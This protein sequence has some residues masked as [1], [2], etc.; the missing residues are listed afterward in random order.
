MVA[1][2]AIPSGY[3]NAIACLITGAALIA[4][5][6]FNESARDPAQLP[7][8]ADG[9]LVQLVDLHFGWGIQ[10]GLATDKQGNVYVADSHRNRIVRVGS[11]GAWAVIAGAGEPGYRDGPGAMA[12]F[13]FPQGLAVDDAGNVFVADTLNEVIRK[14]SAR[15][16]VTTIAGSY[17]W[18]HDGNVRDRNPARDGLGTEARFHAPD[19][20][21]LDKKGSVFVSD[22]QNARIRKVRPD[23][24]VSTLSGV[25]PYPRLGFVD[26]PADK[27][28]FNYPH[29]IAVGPDGNIYVA[30]NNSIRKISPDGFT[31]TLAGGLRARQAQSAGDVFRYTGGFANGRGAEAEFANPVALAIDSKGIIYVA[32]EN[33]FAIRR[34]TLEGE[35]TTLFDLKN[36][37]PAPTN[38]PTARS[39]APLAVAVLPD[40]RLV[41]AT[42]KGIFIAPA[43]L[44]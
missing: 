16:E 42:L 33:N 34:V 7:G 27:A 11:D 12:R 25:W 23:G 37:Y 38:P 40:D 1:N 14:I 15:G 19:S 31:Y 43:G 32:D 9:S 3:L 26:G 2:I 35:T 44:R 4:G 21:A 5:C 20:I 10:I 8:R 36:H 30:D 28:A 6:S 18:Y 17:R 39:G 41:I 13:S 24:A 29:G 22:T